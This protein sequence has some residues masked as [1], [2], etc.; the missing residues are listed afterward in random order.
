MY[1]DCWNDKWKCNLA[2]LERWLDISAIIFSFPFRKNTTNK[3]QISIPTAY[4]GKA[5]VNINVA[6]AINNL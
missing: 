3:N 1:E 5:K 6:N 4:V 2:N